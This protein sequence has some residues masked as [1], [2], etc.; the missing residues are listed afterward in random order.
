MA[1][2]TVNLTGT[3]EVD[4]SAKVTYE[5][6]F[7]AEYEQGNVMDQFV[8]FAREIGAKSVSMPRYG[9]LTPAETALT[10]REDVDSEAMSDTEILL[11]PQE[12]GNAVT[13]TEL[14][15]LQSGGRVSRA[16]VRQIASN[17][18]RTRNVHGIRAL[19]AT[20]NAL[21]VAASE[22]ATVAGD[23]ITPQQLNKLYNKMSRASVPTVM[24]GLYVAF[25]HDDV[26]H[27]LRNETGAGSWSDITKRTDGDSTLRNAIGIL[28]GFYIVRNNDCLIN[29]DGG[30]GNVDTYTSSFL[31]M[32]GLGLAESME[33]Q[34]VMAGP[35]DKLQ[36]FYNV[37]WKGCYK[38]QVI[39]PT[40]AWKLISASSIGA[41]A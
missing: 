33:A 13:V 1:D 29:A 26:I 34:L 28:N 20:S 6:D 41:N 21:T 19:E 4:D 18:A 15:D 9:A 40:A 22:A 5:N 25:L 27:D 14:A 30:N 8:E 16:A 38:Y 37:G 39:E 2:F 10:E 23:V 12:H 11:T 7:I 3:V 32:N 35:F 24:D 17:M 36:R 31:G